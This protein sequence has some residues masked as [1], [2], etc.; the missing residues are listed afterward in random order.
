MVLY[1]W[2]ILTLLLTSGYLNLVNSVLDR[3][4]IRNCGSRYSGLNFAILPYPRHEIVMDYNLY[5]ALLLGKTFN[6]PALDISTKKILKEIQGKSKMDCYGTEITESDIRIQWYVDTR[7]DFPYHNQNY[8]DIVRS[9]VIKCMDIDSF[10]TVS[11]NNCSN[12]KIS[13]LD[14]IRHTIDYYSG[15]I[16]ANSKPQHFQLA[17]CS[18]LASRD[19]SLTFANKKGSYLKTSIIH[20]SIE[21]FDSRDL[22]IFSPLSPM[23]ASL[24]T[25]ISVIGSIASVTSKFSLATMIAVYG[26]IGTLVGI[27]NG[28]I[29]T[30]NT[31]AAKSVDQNAAIEGALK[32]IRR[33]NLE[34]RKQYLQQMENMIKEQQKTNKWLSKISG[35]MST[36]IQILQDIKEELEEIN[37]KLDEFNNT[38]VSYNSSDT[39]KVTIPLLN[40]TDDIKSLDQLHNP[41]IECPLLELY[42]KLQDKF[43]KLGCDSFKD[44][45]DLYQDVTFVIFYLTNLIK[46][47]SMFAYKKFRFDSTVELNIGKYDDRVFHIGGRHP[48]FT[49]NQAKL[50]RDLSEWKKEVNETEISKYYEKSLLLFDLLESNIYQDYKVANVLKFQNQMFLTTSHGHS[51]VY[52]YLEYFLDLDD[53]CMTF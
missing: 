17:T 16:I 15:F 47:F 35:Q 41:V 37:S 24:L 28:V 25:V 2:L 21:F 23:I 33:Q 53:L 36:V 13:K 32:E 19:T 40:Y 1:N 42:D 12:T 4:V 31:Y 20:Y 7:M 22:F 39:A 45:K 10:S 27:I 49:K 44:L 34:T 9:R 11:D 29:S 26:A 46:G 3:D 48:E 14:L 5:C 30:Q 51:T 8:A 38:D 18:N 52:D 50:D 43:E 6:S